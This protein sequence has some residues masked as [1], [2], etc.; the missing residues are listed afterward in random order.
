LD[1][2]AIPALVR[3]QVDSDD[4][5]LSPERRL[6]LKDC[7]RAMIEDLS[8]DA[9]ADS[10]SIT[11]RAAP[12]IIEGAPGIVCVAGRNELDE[13]AASLLVHLLHS[14]QSAGIAKALPAEALTLDRYQSSLEHAAVICLSLISTHSAVRAR[15]IVR[16]LS[17]RAPR[18]RVLV[19]F[20][21]L[22]PDELAATVATI[23][24]P[25]AVVVTSLRGA[26]RNL[27]S[28]P[29]LDGEPGR[30]VEAIRA[31]GVR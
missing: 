31:T 26:V 20:W 17:R 7:I 15:Y 1:E 4:G 8:G 22:S 18:A 10:S 11:E 24:R 5:I 16:R 14:E 3:A 23:A 30:A 19:G 28:D 2:V 13:A 21:R 6:M 27:Q 9:P 25:D 12:P 29:T